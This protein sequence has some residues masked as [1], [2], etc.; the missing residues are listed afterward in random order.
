MPA[1]VGTQAGLQ[2]HKWPSTALWGSSSARCRSDRQRFQCCVETSFFQWSLPFFCHQRMLSSKEKEVTS[3]CAAAA[4]L[5]YLHPALLQERCRVCV[6]GRRE[7][8]MRYPPVSIMAPPLLNASGP[9]HPCSL[10]ITLLPDCMD[11]INIACHTCMK[12][13]C[14]AVGFF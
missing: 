3:Q 11:L 10:I 4:A 8:R 12:P 5:F 14:E 9:C 7:N 2:R 1:N 13:T 6:Y